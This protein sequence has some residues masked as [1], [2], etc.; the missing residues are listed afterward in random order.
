ML[1]FLVGQPPSLSPLAGTNK[2]QIFVSPS[3]GVLW[4]ADNS[5]V[6]R[7]NPQLNLTRFVHIPGVH[8]SA[9]IEPFCLCAKTKNYLDLFYFVR[10]VKCGALVGRGKG[11][12]NRIDSWHRCL[13]RQT[14]QGLAEKQTTL[15]C[16]LTAERS[17]SCGLT[18]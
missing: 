13:R 14:E 12:T 5:S 4:H 3:F 8:T 16:F 2:A 6:E 9:N 10:F 1:I 15:P 17:G 7:I 18:W 11:E